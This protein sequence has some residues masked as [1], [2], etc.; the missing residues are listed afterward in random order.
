MGEVIDYVKEYAKQ[1]TTGPLMGA[2]RWIGL[3]AAGAL[4]LG[5]GLLLL[6]LGLL[7]V[8]QTE[9]A[10]VDD[11][12]WSWLPYLI[13]LIVCAGLIAVAVSRINKTYLDKK[14]K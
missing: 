7:R 6:L 9:W 3:G 8:L 13:V 2:G 5:I 1:E 14:D 10:F 11:R 12:S 4:T